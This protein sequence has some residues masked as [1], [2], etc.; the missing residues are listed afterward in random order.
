LHGIGTQ[1]SFPRRHLHARY[2]VRNSQLRGFSEEDVEQLG[3]LVRYHRGPPPKKKHRG[4][5][6]VGRAQR[7]AV[8]LL[9]G[10]LR[11]AV[12]L[13]R[14]QTQV[15]KRVTGKRTKGTLDLVVAGIG[16][17]ELELWAAR[18]K[19]KP[20]ADVLGLDVRVLSEL[21]ARAAEATPPHVD[22]RAPG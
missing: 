6:G 13:D 2:I 8:R 21:E 14:G 11:I 3:L 18:R 12:A 4:M 17:L 19:T 9:S 16:D 5:H 7:R 15:V 10:I 1:L 22:E 20:L